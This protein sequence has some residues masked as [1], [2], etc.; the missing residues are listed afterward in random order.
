MRYSQFATRENVLEP[1]KPMYDEIR[2]H[3]NEAIFKNA[4]PI[5]VELGCG[6]G[7]YTTGLAAQFPDRNFV[8]MDVKGDRM[9]R[10]AGLAEDEGLRNV[11]FLRATIDFLDKFFAPGEIAEVWIPFPD[12]RPKEA[13]DKRRLTHP[14]YLSM[15]R[16][17]MQPGG[18][19]HFK[20]DDRPLFDYSLEV[21]RRQP[22]TDLAFTHDLYASD[23]LGLQHG[24]RTK[25]ERQFIKQG[26]KINYLH[27][28]FEETGDG[29]TEPQGSQ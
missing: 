15:Y 20:T 8:G 28:R 7:E 23:L 29:G 1:G 16:A 6:G 12:P 9:W 18:L 3:W 27:F 24:I 17:L 2:G 13:Q 10:G 11:A 25:Y 4:N 14:R 5:T 22:V 21:L 26:I 19:V